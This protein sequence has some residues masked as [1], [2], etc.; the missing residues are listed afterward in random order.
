MNKNPNDDY[1]AATDLDIQTGQSVPHDDTLDY[2][3]PADKNQYKYTKRSKATLEDRLREA[4]DFVY[5]VPHKKKHKKKKNKGVKIFGIIMSV[6]A[7][8]LILSV[9][10]VMIFNQVGKS[11]MHDY[12]DMTIEP[13]PQVEDI[14]S[15]DNSG[16]TITYKGQT[17]TFNEEVAT[18]VLMGVDIKDFE[19]PDREV[20]EGGQADAIYIAVIDTN[21]DKVT[22]LGVSRDTMV[23]VNVYNTDGGFVNTDN[24]QLCLSYA[25]GD[26]KHTSCEN[27][28]TSLER[29]F[30]GMQFDTYF[31]I[32]T[33]ALETLTD[34]VGGVNVTS[35]VDFYS[36]NYCRTIYAGENITLYGKDSTMYVRSRDIEELDS[37]NDRM[38][39]QKQFMTA[40]LK[41]M[42][43]S[44]KSDPS[45]I[46]DLYSGIT[47]YSTTNLTT[48]KMT[49]LATTAMSGLD[50]YKEIEFVNVAGTVK[51]GEYAE[52]HIDQDALMQTM[53]DIFYVKVQ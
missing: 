23:D 17:Y 31:A 3:F 51:K 7:A 49:Y 34:A 48:S 26:G 19:Y 32:D 10:T 42:W 41:Q 12:E 46:S 37:N 36:S 21:K 38:S 5:A 1:K 43:P 4:D 11:A 22:I 25:Y 29:L 20:G 27:T 50:S 13:S 53:L 14:E 16:K 15:I 24:M 47:A 35:L 45:V 33:R 8:I 9:S 52:F 6:I 28:I 40:F 18:V 44:V 39:R 2:V 30:Y